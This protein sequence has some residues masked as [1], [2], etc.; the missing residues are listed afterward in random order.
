MFSTTV[1]KMMEPLA[2]QIGALSISSSTPTI[3]SKTDNNT[4]KCVKN[5]ANKNNNNV[6]TTPQNNTKQYNN[7]AQWLTGC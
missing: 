1:K 3:T 2:Q 7:E 5:T 4:Q 6:T